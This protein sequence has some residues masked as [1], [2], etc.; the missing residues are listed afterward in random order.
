MLRAIC[1]EECDADSIRC[2]VASA[3]RARSADFCRSASLVPITE[4]TRVL[5]VGSN[6]PIASATL[7]RR[8]SAAVA[9]ASWYSVKLVATSN[10]MAW[11]TTLP[12]FATAL[13]ERRVFRAKA[14][15]AAL[16]MRV[17]KKI[18]VRGVSPSSACRELRC[19]LERI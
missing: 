17:P 10:A 4:L 9:S 15:R 8:L 18:R 19:R 3:P 6:S 13:P 12:R 7:I 11:A 14:L 2:E 5:S 16:R 1:T